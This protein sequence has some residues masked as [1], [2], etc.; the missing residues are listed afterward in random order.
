MGRGG[1]RGRSLKKKVLDLLKSEDLDLAID[2]LC[3]LPP[4]HVINPLFS[5]LYNSNEKIKWRAVTAMGAIVSKLADEDMESARIIMRRLMWNLND[6]SGGI[7]WGSPEAM[8]E[9]LACHETLANEYSQ[10]LI[11]YAREDGNFQEHELM[12]RGVLWGIGRLA[13]S[14]PE[15]LI[16]AVTYLIPYLD[17]SDATV[18]GLAVWILGLLGIE[19]GW[20]KLEQLTDDE[21]QLKIYID[22]RLIKCKVKEL[23]ENAFGKENRT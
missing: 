13:Q 18:R 16:D 6:E 15:L 17:S 22:R 7:G 1:L 19:G 23:A 9:I 21:N 12:Q 11:S 14:N 3:R 10:I 8:G 2:Q 5:F 20:S 4:R